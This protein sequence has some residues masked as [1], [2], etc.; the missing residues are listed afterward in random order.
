MKTYVVTYHVRDEQ[1]PA[2][3]AC[4]SL[5]EAK[6][7]AARCAALLGVVSPAYW[8][9]PVPWSIGA[10]A[11]LAGATTVSESTDSDSM[12]TITELELTL[13][14]TVDLDEYRVVDSSNGLVLL[15]HIPC[16]DVI[17]NTRNVSV[18]HT[19]RISHAHNLTCTERSS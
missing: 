2:L 6:D 12:F 8:R 15:V 4:S 19:V 11:T 5:E 14:V 13:P 16:G 1:R 17:L 3:A 18:H 9:K 10:R 7:T